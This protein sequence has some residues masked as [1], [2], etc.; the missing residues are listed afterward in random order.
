MRGAKTQLPLGSEQC[1]HER[2][3]PSFF[4]F[5]SATSRCW[6]S[7]RPSMSSSSNSCAHM[8]AATNS[9]QRGFV[10]NVDVACSCTNGSYIATASAVSR[11]EPA[12][13]RSQPCICHPSIC[14]PLQ[15]RAVAVRATQR[16][17]PWYELTPQRPPYALEPLP[18][19]PTIAHLYPNIPC[20]NQTKPNQIDPIAGSTSRNATQRSRLGMR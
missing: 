19:L 12:R 1:R 3:A 5:T 20:N 13:T 10:L 15:H 7:R 6:P 4:V 18:F 2:H 14:P 11:S 8:T 17:S 9:A 16:C